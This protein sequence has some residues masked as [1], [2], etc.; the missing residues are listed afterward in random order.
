ME[1][2]VKLARFEGPYTKLLDLIQERKL[3]ITEID[4]SSIADD[5]I[6]YTKTLEAKDHLDISHFIVVASTLMLMKVKSLLPHTD[7]TS[8]EEKEAANLTKKLLLLDFL[9][10]T[11]TVF[12]DCYG[13]KEFTGFARTRIHAKDY[14]APS[15]LTLL[16]VNEAKNALL[17][18]AK[19]NALFHE[20]SVVR[21]YT[22]KDATNILRER[23]E[24]R[25]SFTQACTFIDDRDSLVISF[26]SLLELIRLGE[27]EATQELHS[28][29]LI[30][31]IARVTL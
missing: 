1:Y 4:L 21:K 25:M 5:Y 24:G 8:V 19:K 22:M 16:K 12:R 10:K 13:S 14:A 15:N 9:Q 11:S 28:P 20:I 6:T 30:E 23:V 31:K 27:F 3:S 7:Y 26:L 29:I 17:Q 2:S 18:I